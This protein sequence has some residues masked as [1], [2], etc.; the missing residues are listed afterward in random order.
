M[1]ERFARVH[2]LRL[3]ENVGGAGGFHRGMAWAYA[4]GHT[5]LW[6]MDDD[7][8][9]RP[10][11][12]RTLLEGAARAPGAPALVASRVLWKDGSLH[13]M[14]SPWP[15]W[16]SPDQLLDGV[17]AGLL[18]LRHATFVSVAVHREAVTAHG[19]P[20]AHYFIWTDDFEYT[21]R[22]LRDGRGYLVPESVA[23]HWTARPHSPVQAGG[24]R[25]YYFVRNGLLL[26]RGRSL[27]PVERVHYA[28][29][30]LRFVRA[31]LQHEHWSAAA[32]AVVA[33]GVRDGLRGAVR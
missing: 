12:L 13:P 10:D 8:F 18:A 6:L 7:T 4:R 14:N 32:L 3:E 20:L 25:F 1:A 5:W 27:E 26:L 31:Y 22:I 21:G 33:R 30:S 15:R 24:G 28:R 16:R 9:T 29:M 19:L 17:R 11:T 2:V 23:D